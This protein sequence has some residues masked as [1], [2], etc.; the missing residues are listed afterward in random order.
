[1]KTKCSEIMSWLWFSVKI[2]TVF[3]SLVYVLV[4]IV[5]K[6]QYICITILLRNRYNALTPY[7]KKIN[8]VVM[9]AILQKNNT[10]NK[11]NRE[12][13]ITHPISALLG[14]GQSD[15][16]TLGH[17]RGCCTALDESPM[18]IHLMKLLMKH[19]WKAQLAPRSTLYGNWL[20]ISKCWYDYGRKINVSYNSQSCLEKNCDF[21]VDI[22]PILIIQIE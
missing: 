18:R 10:C 3:S 17:I 8:G 9:I 7:I 5:F 2:F 15:C 16:W 13:V 6:I 11:R 22:A 20:Q 4:I 12:G 1:M 14:I 19:I 21:S